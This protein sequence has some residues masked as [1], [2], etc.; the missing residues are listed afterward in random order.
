MT[1][2]LYNIVEKEQLIE[3]LTAFQVCTELPVQVIDENGNV[4]ISLGEEALFC[5][6]FQKHLPPNDTC[7]RIHVAASKKAISL[8]ETYIFSCHANLNHIVFPIINKNALF[9][10][11]VVGPFLMD[12]PDSLLI[13]DITKR[14]TIPTVS[15]LELYETSNDLAVIPPS[16]ATQISRRKLYYRYRNCH[17]L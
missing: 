8:G 12:K 14:Y 13:L 16:K 5:K 17:R 3:M 1:P 7:E 11:V 4:I 9:G 2:H 15:L 6:E 10:S